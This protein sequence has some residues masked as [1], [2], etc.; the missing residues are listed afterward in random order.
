MFKPTRW[1]AVLVVAALAIAALGTSVVGAKPTAKGKTDSGFVF[2][3]LTHSKGKTLYIAGGATDK[4][5]GAGAVTFKST[6]TTK[7]GTTTI[8]VNPVVLYFKTGSL[9]GTASAK[10]TI[11][12]DHTVT[13]TGGKIMA[14]K[15]AGA[16][17]G[18]SL[19]ATFTGSGS[20]V[21]GPYQFVY[22]GTFK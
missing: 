19:T 11:N 15:G 10:V 14:T 12:A 2:A 18:H 20:A 5:F 22:K 16:L 21:T 13:I 6:L 8:K 17:K 4:R 3:A 7:A 9:T 1:L